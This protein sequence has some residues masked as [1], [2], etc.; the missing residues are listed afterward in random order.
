MRTQTWW[1]FAR[2][3]CGVALATTVLLPAGVSAWGGQPLNLAL[4]AD[5]EV[6]LASIP[7]PPDPPRLPPELV[8]R[9]PELV[10]TEEET[11]ALPEELTAPAPETPTAE[12]PSTQ[13]ELV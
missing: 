4:P 7:Q 2:V 6:Q 9:F 3:L 1:F 12:T 5:T 11:E 8:E 10:P 13:P